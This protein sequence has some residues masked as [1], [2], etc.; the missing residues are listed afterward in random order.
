M[1]QISSYQVG[2]G[3]EESRPCERPQLPE[4]EHPLG[5][6]FFAFILGYPYPLRVE[7]GRPLVVFGVL[8]GGIVT[9]FLF[10]QPLLRRRCRRLCSWRR[11]CCC[12]SLSIVASPRRAHIGQGHPVVSRGGHFALGLPSR[13]RRLS[14][15]ICVRLLSLRQLFLLSLLYGVQ[16]FLYSHVVH[17]RKLAGLIKREVACLHLLYGIWET[18]RSERVFFEFIRG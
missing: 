17:M 3:H 13:W 2:Y 9:V 11:H 1:C 12:A 15:V 5:T 18:V 16:V 7:V 10:F 14:F 6:S 8:V 4:A